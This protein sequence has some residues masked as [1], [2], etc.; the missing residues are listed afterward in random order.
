MIQTMTLADGVTLR[1]FYDNRFKQGALS[2]QLVR[3]MAGGEASLN[4][5]IP[6]ILL[7]GTKKH[8]DLRSITMH[9]DDLY[10]AAVGTMVRRVGDWQ[11]TGLACG[12]MDDRFA[13][14]GDK[15]LEPMIDFLRELLL[16]PCLEDGVFRDD[17]VESEK[18][19]LI[20]TIESDLNDKRVY[21]MNRMLRN[22]CRADALGIPRLGYTEWVAAA[23]PESLYSHYRKILRES[24]IDICYVGSAPSWQVANLLKPILNA[25]DRDYKALP[26]QTPFYDAGPSNEVEHMDV[27]QAKLCMGYTTPITIGTEEFAAMQV[28]NSI[29]GAGMTSKLFQNVREKLSLCYSIGTT[30]Y[31]AKGLVTL[32][33][34][35]DA[36]KEEE[37]KAEI[38]AQLEAVCRGEITQNEMAAAREAILSGLRGIHDSPGAIE[39]YYASAALSGLTW[40]PAEYMEHISAVTAEQVAQAARTLKLHTTY[41]LKGESHEED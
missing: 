14:P 28:M 8:P 39:N 18:K 34:G 41:I 15:V 22:M 32:S 29:F 31:S 6:A 2:F 38:A 37:A 10:G 4:A 13:L 5:L 36:A 12:M 11:T 40:S 23:T 33:A 35:I 21:A 1:C 20:A 9:L 25:L 19:N 27:A 30:Y 16:E 24:R 7:R 3:P 17:F 26:A